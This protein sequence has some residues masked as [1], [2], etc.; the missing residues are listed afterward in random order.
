MGQRIKQRRATAAQWTATNPVLESGEFG[1]ES[2]TNKLKI[3]NGASAWS[4]LAYFSAGGSLQEGV[5]LTY[6]GN[7]ILVTANMP[8]GL[9]QLP[10]IVQLQAKCLTAVNGFAVGDIV[11]PVTSS[12]AWGADATNTFLTRSNVG[13]MTTPPKTGG[14]ANV[15][16]LTANWQ[17]IVRSFI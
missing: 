12:F 14:A 6:A 9:P 13:A 2:D 7:N 5:P 11:V 17:I 3:G 1:W 10:K 4:A 15:S 8:H 16:I